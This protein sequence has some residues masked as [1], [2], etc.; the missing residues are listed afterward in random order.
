[1]HG[2]AYES[3]VALMRAGEKCTWGWPGW[4]KCWVPVGRNIQKLKQKEEEEEKRRSKSKQTSKSSS[5]KVRIVEE[6]PE[7]DTESGSG[8][9]KVSG[10]SSGSEGVA[11]SPP[12]SRMGSIKKASK[13]SYLTTVE[14]GDESDGETSLESFENTEEVK[15]RSK[16]ASRTPPTSQRQTSRTPRARSIPNETSSHK[17]ISSKPISRSRSQSVESQSSVVTIDSIRSD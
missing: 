6:E 13:P 4:G 9:E 10:S 11:F 12:V 14:S 7:S 15:S 16:S 2:G 17:K 3:K 1:M 8:S 5:K